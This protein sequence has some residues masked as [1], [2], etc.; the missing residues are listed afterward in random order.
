MMSFVC[1]YQIKTIHD[2]A[3]HGPEK[4]NLTCCSLHSGEVCWVTS[5]SLLNCRPDLQWSCRV[6][7]QLPIGLDRE[8]AQ[9]VVEIAH[10][11]P[12]NSDAMFKRMCRIE[13]LLRTALSA[14]TRQEPVQSSI[15]SYETP[16]NS[17]QDVDKTSDFDSLLREMMGDDY[18]VLEDM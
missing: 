7:I 16:G 6:P 5:D 10:P 17:Q 1:A 11:Y 8:H 18:G 12:V 3:E 4:A 9:S 13:A 15:A 14:A 2:V